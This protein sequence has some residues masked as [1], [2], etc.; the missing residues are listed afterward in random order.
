MA[1]ENPKNNQVPS[2]QETQLEVSVQQQAFQPETSSDD[3]PIGYN[4]YTRR[5]RWQGGRRI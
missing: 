5:P 4:G 1:E 3:V 2:E